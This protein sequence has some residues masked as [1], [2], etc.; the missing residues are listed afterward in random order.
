MAVIAIG[1]IQ[2]CWKSLKKLLKKTGFKESKDTL[3]IVGDLVN[4]GPES[5][6]VVRSIM[7]MGDAAITVLGNHDLHFLAVASGAETFKPKDTFRDILDSPQLEDIVHWYRQRPLLHVQNRIALTHAGIWPGWSTKKALRRAREVEKVL[8]GEDWIEFLRHMYGN[9]PDLWSGKLSG[10]NRL[11]FITNA[12]TRMRYVDHELRLNLSIKG[13][14][15]ANT[16]L[17]PWFKAPCK[18]RRER[19]VFG[20]WSALGLYNDMS[21]I[22]LD[23][24]CIW[25]NSLTAVRLDTSPVRFYSVD[26]RR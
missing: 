10:W 2:G 20:H 14:A 5:L 22:G 26:C 6:S 18:P 19:I 1:D 13:R 4:R 16:H 11:R 15:D 24:G 17:L 21:V 7:D 23:T 8:Q 3:L 9:R 25:G 12:F